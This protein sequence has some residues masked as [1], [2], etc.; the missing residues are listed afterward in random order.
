M[1]PY[2]QQLFERIAYAIPAGILI[3]MV[4]WMYARFRYATKLGAG[5]GLWLAL[6]F[7]FLF[8]FG[9]YTYWIVWPKLMK[10]DLAYGPPPAEET[11]RNINA[12]APAP[13][14]ALPRK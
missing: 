6:A 9:A 7:L 4:P 13:A 2:T 14:R 8:A 11:G 12:P 10:E 1:D 5:R 3:G